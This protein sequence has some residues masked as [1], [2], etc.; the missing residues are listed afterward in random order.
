MIKE[1][2]RWKDFIIC[3]YAAFQIE[4]EIFREQEVSTFFPARCP[5]CKWEGSSCELG[6]E[7]TSYEYDEFEIWCIRCGCT[8]IEERASSKTQWFFVRWWYTAM[9]KWK[10]RNRN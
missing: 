3:L 10:C 8:D 7:K 1:L 9:W 4:W 6:E 2:K 5:K